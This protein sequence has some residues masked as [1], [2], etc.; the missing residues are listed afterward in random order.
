MWH[1]L[2]K[3]AVIGKLNS[4]EKGLDEKEAEIRLERYG[5]NQIEEIYKI[6]P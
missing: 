6:N 5:K 3:E 4:N 2:S 1:T